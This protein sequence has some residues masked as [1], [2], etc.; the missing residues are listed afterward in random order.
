VERIPAPRLHGRGRLATLAL[1]GA[2]ALWLS[3]AGGGRAETASTTQ[4]VR[5]RVIESLGWQ[6]GPGCTSPTTEL[7]Q[8]AHGNGRWDIAAQH[9]SRARPV[10]FTLNAEDR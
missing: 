7:R 3:A 8:C 9:R 2:A 1:A 4:A 10:T 5:V 6:T